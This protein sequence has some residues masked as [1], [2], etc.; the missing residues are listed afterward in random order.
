MFDAESIPLAESAPI[1]PLRC[2]TQVVGILDL[3]EVLHKRSPLREPSSAEGP[4]IVLPFERD[5]ARYLHDFNIA[6]N[7]HSPSDRGWN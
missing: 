5:G 1:D 2:R 3:V 7:T 4:R 6:S